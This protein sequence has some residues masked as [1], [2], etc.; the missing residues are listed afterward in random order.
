MEF[1]Q[2]IPLKPPPGTPGTHYRYFIPF[3]TLAFW[4]GAIIL[5]IKPTFS[6]RL[7]SFRKCLSIGSI[8]CSP[9]CYRVG[10]VYMSK[11]QYIFLNCNKTNL[12]K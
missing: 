8:C 12:V 1:L 5:N 3:P 7:N 6:T 9:A 4:Y 11:L 2:V 10:V